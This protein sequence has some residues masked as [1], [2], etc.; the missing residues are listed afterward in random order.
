[1]QYLVTA[2]R[3][4]LTKD[5]SKDVYSV[6]GLVSQTPS[7]APAGSSTKIMAHSERLI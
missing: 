1:M 6:Q 5:L 4:S 3:N 2:G 7:T